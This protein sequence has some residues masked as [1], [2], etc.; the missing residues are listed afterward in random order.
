MLMKKLFFLFM[1]LAMGIYA[2]A[3]QLDV[4]T[5]PYGEDGSEI[6]IIKPTVANFLQLLSMTE[7][8]FKAVMEANKYSTQMPR[9]NFISYWNGSPDNFQYA[10][11]VNSFLYNKE[12]KEVHFAVGN[13]MIYPQGSLMQLYRDLQP[14]RK[15][16]A[17]NAQPGLPTPPNAQPGMPTPP[18]AQSGMPIPPNAAPGAG[19]GQGARPGAAPG[20]NRMGRGRGGFGRGGFGRARTDTFEVKNDDGTIYTFTIAANPRFFYITASKKEAAK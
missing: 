4:C 2:Q 6:T 18:N 9:G 16:G 20:R 13:D 10:K 11:C 1:M 5:K 15:E 8:Q 19:F 14:Y 12:T 17:E 3:Q 7:D